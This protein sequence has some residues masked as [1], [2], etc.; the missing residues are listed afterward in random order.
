MEIVLNSTLAGG[1]IMGAAADLIN[2][3]YHAMI[4]GWAIGV[5]SA[6]GYVYITPYLKKKI[7]LHDTCGVFNLHG[8]PGLMGGFVSAITCSRMA[9]DNFGKR[10]ADYF[11]AGRTT[12]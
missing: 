2:Y 6:V 8:V 11:P 10:Y 7:M 1:V 3:P 4:A 9:E 5:F 12:A